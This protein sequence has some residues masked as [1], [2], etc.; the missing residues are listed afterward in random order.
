[1]LFESC[2]AFASPKKITEPYPGTHKGDLI[3]SFIDSI[4]ARDT[5]KAE[6][7][8]QDVFDTMSV[9][10]AIEKATSQE[11]FIQVNLFK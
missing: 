11:S 4:I 9:C 3:H 1:M 7:T 5:S 10:F 2:D 6:V 8:K